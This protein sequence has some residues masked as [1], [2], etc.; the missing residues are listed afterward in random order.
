M[1]VSNSVYIEINSKKPKGE[2]I[3]KIIIQGKSLD[4]NK[5]YIFSALSQ[6]LEGKDG[7]TPMN[8]ENYI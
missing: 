3:Q 7:F 4:D 8:E 6:P 1:V 2:K 5:E